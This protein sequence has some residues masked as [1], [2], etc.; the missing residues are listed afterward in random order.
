MVVVALAAAAALLLV[1]TQVQALGHTA[2]EPITLIDS[3]NEVHSD[4]WETNIRLFQTNW[5]GSCV[6]FNL[7]VIWKKVLMNDVNR[8]YLELETNKSSNFK[9]I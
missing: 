3:I 4:A 1:L 5:L 7:D 6:L 2:T 9:V 8:G